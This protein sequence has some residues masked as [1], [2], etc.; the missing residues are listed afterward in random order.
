MKLLYA[1]NPPINK[2][3]TT[4]INNNGSIFRSCEFL[5]AS[6]QFVPQITK[7][8]KEKLLNCLQTTLIYHIEQDSSLLTYFSQTILKM[9]DQTKSSVQ[10]QTTQTTTEKTSTTSTIVD[11]NVIQDKD[12]VLF[13]CLDGS[14]RINQIQKG[15]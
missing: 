9:E 3:K 15:G 14:S 10:T 11:T 12:Y 2:T 7:L 4:A 5:L 6:I 1:K 8:G 13:K